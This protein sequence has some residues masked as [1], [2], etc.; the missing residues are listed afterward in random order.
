MQSLILG[1]D[2]TEAEKLRVKGGHLGCPRMESL[3]LR[4]NAA[5]FDGHQRWEK[6]FVCCQTLLKTF[7]RTCAAHPYIIA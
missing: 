1:A 4:A 6:G 5:G 3:I 2:A 7:H